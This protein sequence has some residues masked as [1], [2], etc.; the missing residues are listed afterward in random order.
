MAYCFFVFLHRPRRTTPK[1]PS[2]RMATSSNR[3][4]G[5]FSPFT[6]S[7][8]L[9]AQTPSFFIKNRSRRV[10]G[11]HRSLIPI[12]WRGSAATPSGKSR[13]RA[14][15]PLA[16]C[17]EET[18]RAWGRHLWHASFRFR[19][20]IH[21]LTAVLPHEPIGGMATHAWVPPGYKYR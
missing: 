1:P 11:V 7:S 12:T 19:Q 15:L 4:L 3:C 21:R 17:R 13:S 5:C 20:G 8:R 2:P 18:G 6:A 10:P 14:S 16:G 9:H